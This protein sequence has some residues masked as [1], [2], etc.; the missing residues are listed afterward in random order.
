MEAADGRQDRFGFF[1][2]FAR[3][4]GNVRGFAIGQQD[5]PVGKVAIQGTSIGGYWTSVGPSGWYVDALVMGTRYDADPRS[6]R[7]VNATFAGHGVAATVEAGYPIP[8]APGWALEPQGQVIWQYVSLDRFDDVFSS[9]NFAATTPPP[10]ASDCG[11]KA[12]S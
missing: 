10:D 11:C 12:N 1:V 9:V 6:D 3:A 8:V 5:V 4:S 2:G 7:G